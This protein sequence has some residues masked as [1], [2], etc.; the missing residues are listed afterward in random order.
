[1]N[2]RFVVLGVFL[3][4]VGGYAF[5]FPQLLSP[6]TLVS[7]R[8]ILSQVAPGNYSTI[9]ATLT[10]QQTLQASFTSSPE[11]VDFFLMNSSAFSSWNASGH[12]PVDIYPQSTLDAKNY[13]FS[14]TDAEGSDGLS[15]VVISTSPSGS[16]NVLFHLVVS[17]EPNLVQTLAIPVVIIALGVASVAFGA[18]RT[19]KTKVGPSGT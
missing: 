5:A 10:P 15:L 13:T 16:T 3:L 8:T 7:D 2:Y 9:Q 19:K 4:V 1:M 17:R 11:S 12:P 14:V 6:P 18:T